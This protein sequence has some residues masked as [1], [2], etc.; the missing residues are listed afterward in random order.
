MLDHNWH[1]RDSSI[2]P[3]SVGKHP[4]IFSSP[5]FRRKYLPAWI[6]WNICWAKIPE[7]FYDV[8]KKKEVLSLPVLPRSPHCH[9]KQK[10]YQ[11]FL[12]CLTYYYSLSLLCGQKVNE[13]CI[14]SFRATLISRP[15][16]AGKDKYSLGFCTSSHV[17]ATIYFG[18]AER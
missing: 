11:P 12:P 13:D 7:R 17:R 16:I 2:N 15:A 6:P 4:V 8:R 18:Q 9:K 14:Y 10:S 1:L 3:E 5:M